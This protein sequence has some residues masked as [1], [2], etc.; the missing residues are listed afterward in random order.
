LESKRFWLV[1]I[2]VIITCVPCIL[3][4]VA[5][6]LIAAGTFGSLLGILGV[7]WVLAVII[8]APVA[9]TLL[10]FRLRRRRAAPCCEVPAA[11]TPLAPENPPLES[12]SSRLRPS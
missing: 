5:A 3:I 1:P 10:L 11:P 9:T 7:P 12:I 4:P 2:G 6:A 8:A